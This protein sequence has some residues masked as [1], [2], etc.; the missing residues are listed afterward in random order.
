MKTPRFVISISKAN[1]LK[2]QLMTLAMD[3]IIALS[4]SSPQILEI[5]ADRFASFMQRKP[6]WQYFSIKQDSYLTKTNEEK[7]RMINEYYKYMVK[8]KRFLFDFFFIGMPVKK[9]AWF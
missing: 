5:D 9:T 7:T 3:R 1:V 6:I 4:E 8:G 2:L